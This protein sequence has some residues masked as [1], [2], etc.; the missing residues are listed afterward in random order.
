VVLTVKPG[1][2]LHERG[3]LV[4]NF[5]EPTETTIVTMTN[6]FDKDP[7]G[8]EIPVGLT[9]EVKVNAQNID[10]AIIKAKGIGDGVTSFAS[11]C[12]GLG[13]P[14]VREELAYETTPGAS[15]R[16]LLQFFHDVPVSPSRREI[17]HIAM[18]SMMDKA[19][20]LSNSD[21][22]DRVVRAIR[23]YRR[24]SLAIDALEKFTWYWTGLEALNPLL[25]DTFHV[26]V[27]TPRASGIRAAVHNLLQEGKTLYPRMRDLRNGLV[28]SGSDLKTMT[29]DA[30]ALHNVT[31]EVLLR[32]ILLVLD[33]SVTEKFLRDTISSEPP[34]IAAVVATLH[35]LDPSNLGPPGEHPHFELKSHEVKKTEV[36]DHGVTSTITTNL[37]VRVASGVT[38][39]SYAWRLYG[40]EVTLDQ[41]DAKKGE[42]SN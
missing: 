2:R 24:G 4:F 8:N 9:L 18:I 15:D 39:T 25:Q 6:I 36:T 1:S 40:Q 38:I 13:M 19:I 29:P 3:K 20:N 26:T 34:L 16:S 28:H 10:E 31:R 37:V 11:L 32:A 21:K 27:T 7:A 5:P 30:L 14:T 33:V 23:W 17:D 12:S 42:K 41:V 22:K 35:G